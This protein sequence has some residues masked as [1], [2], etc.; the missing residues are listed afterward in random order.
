MTSASQATPP[1][2]MA[3]AANVALKPPTKL[4]L[5]ENT[6]ENW[7]TYKQQWQNYAIV[8]NLAAQPEEYQ[9]V[10]FLH[11]LGTD[12]LR[13]YNGLSF[14]TEEDKKKLSKIMEKLDEYAIGEVNESYKRYVFN[15]RYQQPDESIDAYMAWH[16]ASWRKLVIYARVCTVVLSGTDRSWRE[17]QATEEKTPSREKTHPE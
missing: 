13:V 2:G 12:V 6:L 1:T 8:A 10:L 4:N 14:A 17:K 7:K 9:V 16:Y 5:R 15:S 3:P 11:C